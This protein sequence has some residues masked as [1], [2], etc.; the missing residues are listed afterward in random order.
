MVHYGNRMKRLK[1]CVVD[2]E[3]STK[4]ESELQMEKEMRDSEKL[5]VNI[6]D[7]LDNSSFKVGFAPHQLGS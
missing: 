4:L 3:L 7:F 5:P 2:Q 1:G 6:Q